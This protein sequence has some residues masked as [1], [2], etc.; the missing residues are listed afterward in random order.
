MW[1]LV[2]LR[3][4]HEGEHAA[5]KFLTFSLLELL[6]PARFVS[7]TIALLLELLVL[8]LLLL[9]LPILLGCL[10]FRLHDM[11]M[12][13]AWLRKR[14]ASSVDSWMPAPTI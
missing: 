14:L 12:K 13:R 6:L 7:G 4:L 2:N 1:G 10:I 11:A 8:V 5:V 3:L 9:T